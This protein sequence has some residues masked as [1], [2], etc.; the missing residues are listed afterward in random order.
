MIRTIKCFFVSFLLFISLI[1]CSSNSASTE[2]K[3]ENSGDK[4][5]KKVTIQIDGAAVP[6]YA[7]LYV[8]K[9]KGYFKEEGLEVEF[10][11]AAAAD[12]VKNVAVG[13]VQFGFPNG[14]S[15]ITARSQGIPV[16][17]VHTTYQ[18]GLGATIFKK[19]KGI[20]DP[21]DLKGKTI[22]VASY[23]S[24]NYIQLQVLLQQNGLNIDD[25]KVKIIGTGSIVNALV[26]DEVDAITF[27]LLR[28]VELRNQG[29][30]VDEF[31]SDDFLPSH[32]NVLVTSEE[33]LASDK[34]TV[35]GFVNALDKG[36]KYIIDG[37]AEDAIDLSISKYSPTFAGKEETI[38]TIFDEIFIPYLWQ[39][40]LTKEKGLGT[41]DLKRWQST[42]DTLKE[43]DV[44]KKEIKA[45]D[46]VVNIKK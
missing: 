7:P 15:V 8:A 1:G 11:Y 9:E 44:I 16:N 32:G 25:V 46:F 38:K 18:N 10:L 39:S 34:E 23:G 43:Y 14:D 28:T 12:I 40:D 22:G 17:V 26:G 37:N 6:Y 24:P 36:L 20:S 29:E 3:N 31:R 13:N 5:L 42:I 19:D 27:S 21:I 30:Q 41:A 4:D 45:E 35:L 33:Y 2:P